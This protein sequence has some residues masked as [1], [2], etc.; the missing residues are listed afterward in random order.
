M[1]EVGTHRHIYFENEEDKN[2][3][4]IHNEIN[5]FLAPHN[6]SINFY[7]Y[8]NDGEGMNCTLYLTLNEDEVSQENSFDFVNDL[9][10]NIFDDSNFTISEC[11]D[12]NIE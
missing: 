4:D 1:Y 5:D 2:L 11:F 7:E 9:L 3:K 10:S 6:I 12:Y 8:L